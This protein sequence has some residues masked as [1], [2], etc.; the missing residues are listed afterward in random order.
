[1][2]NGKKTQFNKKLSRLSRGFTVLNTDYK[3]EVLKTAQ[4]LLRI[5]RT[6]ME[7]VADNAGYSVCSGQHANG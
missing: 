5:Q 4:G 3:K 1:M 7:F 6:R 2:K